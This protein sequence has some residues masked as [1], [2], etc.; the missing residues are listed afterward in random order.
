MNTTVLEMPEAADLAMTLIEIT[1]SVNQGAETIEVFT[2]LA[3]KCVQLLPVAAAGILLRDSNGVLQVIG[4]SNASAHLLDLFQVQN[5]QGPCLKCCNTG[6]VVSDETLTD[7]TNWPRFASL[8]RQH[9]FKAV[10]ALPLKSRGVT[11]GALNLFANESLSEQ[12]LRVAQAL[13]DAATLSLLQVDPEVDYQIV[14][15]RIYLAVESRNTLEQAQG[16]IAQRFSIGVD[17]ALLKLRRVAAETEL[18]LVRVAHAVVNR[19]LTSPAV[20][21]LMVE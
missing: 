18:S 11:I 7:T 10:Y 16:M 14:I 15:R 21:L 2:A 6:E 12:K 4:A 5:E 1:R 13:A 19:D 17:E 8:A 3:E 20:S 9:G